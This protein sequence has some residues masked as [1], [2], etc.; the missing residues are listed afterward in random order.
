MLDMVDLWAVANTNDSEQI[1]KLVAWGYTEFISL[2]KGRL[3]TRV[4]TLTSIA[5][6]QV[7]LREGLAFLNNREF[8][9][10]LDQL[11][12]ALRVTRPFLLG[13]L[14]ILPHKTFIYQRCRC[15]RHGSCCSR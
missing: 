12:V 3:T 6:L 9:V 8:A 10:L 15:H 13:G 2:L 1:L 5:H 11:L 14:R 4:F 7:H